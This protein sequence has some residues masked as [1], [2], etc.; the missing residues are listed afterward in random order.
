MMMRRSHILLVNF[1]F[2]LFQFNTRAARARARGDVVVVTGSLSPVP[3][4]FS[5]SAST[6]SSILFLFL[7]SFV[8][9]PTFSLLSPSSPHHSLVAPLVSLSAPSDPTPDNANWSQT[10]T[11][12][13]SCLT[14]P[15]PLDIS[16][17]VHLTPPSRLFIPLPL[18][19]CHLPPLIISPPFHWPNAVSFAL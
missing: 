16:L 2:Y 14:P 4:P 3:V 6:P 11:P 12:R 7:A 10:S 1:L 18:S 9:P 5:K 19:L 8:R 17:I 15:L 13:P